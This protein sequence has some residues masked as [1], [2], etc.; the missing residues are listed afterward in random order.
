VA[1]KRPHARK[2]QARR[3]RGRR[4]AVPTR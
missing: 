4:N 3:G 2:Q 1:A